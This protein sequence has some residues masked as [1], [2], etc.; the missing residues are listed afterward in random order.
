MRSVFLPKRIDKYKFID[1][2]NNE[3]S[4]IGY[5]IVESETLQFICFPNEENKKEMPFCPKDG[6]KVCKEVCKLLNSGTFNLKYSFYSDDKKV[7]E[8][9]KKKEKKRSFKNLLSQ[10]F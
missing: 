6:Y 9:K 5:G 3:C 4:F 2:K 8:N 10:I 1:S 7:K